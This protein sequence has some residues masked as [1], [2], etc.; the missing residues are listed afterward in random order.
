MKKLLGILV[1][2]L[3]LSSNANAVDCLEGAQFS[4]KYSDYA[5]TALVDDGGE[6][7]D[8]SFFDGFRY[9]ITFK[10]PTKK[11][12]TILGAKLL[13]AENNIMYK[14]RMNVTIKPYHETLISFLAPRGFMND[15]VKNLSIQTVCK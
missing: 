2:G 1:L 11:T 5:E 13:S 6:R 8:G 7:N 12:I 10:N 3:L 4:W 14:Q 15:L 9:Q